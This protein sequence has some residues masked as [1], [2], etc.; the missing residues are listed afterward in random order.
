[1][2]C[3]FKQ[4]LHLDKDYRLGTHDV[5][6]RFFEDRK[7]KHWLNIGLIEVIEYPVPTVVRLADDSPVHAEL[8][9]PM[10]TETELFEVEEL[11]KE[12]DVKERNK[13]KR[14]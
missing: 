5:P 6:D 1:M 12:P 10:G 9:A 3:L 2:K 14:R 8:P 13:K 7:F 11:K 4:S